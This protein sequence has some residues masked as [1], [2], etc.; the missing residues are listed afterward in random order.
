MW[1]CQKASSKNTDIKITERWHNSY[2]VTVQLDCA[3]N[4][5]I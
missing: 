5:K 4:R 3:L 2:V 1:Q